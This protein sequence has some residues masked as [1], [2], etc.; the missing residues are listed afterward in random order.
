MQV[1]KFGGT[2]VASAENIG[3]S[4]AIAAA[5]LQHGPVVMVVSALS[6]TTDALIDIGRAAATGDSESY[7]A[8]VR[9]LGTLN[10]RHCAAARQLLPEEAA[11]HNKIDGQFAGLALVAE[12][13]YALGELS[14]R[15][16]DRL[17][18]TGELLSS[19]LIAAAAQQQGLDAAWV[20]ARQLIRTNSR[21][22]TA[23]VDMAATTMQ[24]KALVSASK[25]RLW[26]VPGFI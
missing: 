23:E 26:V 21:F 22:G 2:S 6:G 5:A 19:R 3:K 8:A 16:L 13:I 10:E 15:T 7:Q 14:P 1:L 11:E 18:S 20:D 9:T 4:V 17:M 25:A 24:V 12:S